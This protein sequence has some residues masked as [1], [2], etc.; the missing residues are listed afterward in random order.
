MFFSSVAFRHTTVSLFETS[1]SSSSSSSLTLSFFF[2]VAFIRW[3]PA[4]FFVGESGQVSV[5]SYINNLHPRKHAAL[6]GALGGLFERFVPLFENV[7]TEMRCGE[8]PLRLGRPEFEPSTEELIPPKVPE[9]SQVPKEKGAEDKDSGTARDVHDTFLSSLA[10]RRV[11]LK[12]RA[13]QVIVKI[14]SIELT[15]ESPQYDGGVWHIEGMRNEQICATGLFYYSC[16]NVRLAEEQE[17][18]GPEPCPDYPDC[19][20]GSGHHFRK[21]AHPPEFIEERRMF[22]DFDIDADNTNSERDEAMRPSD[23]VWAPRRDTYDDLD[24]GEDDGEPATRLAFRSAVQDP[25]YRQG[26]DAG[27]LKTCMFLFLCFLFCCFVCVC[28]CLFV[29]MLSLP[30]SHTLIFFFFFFRI[31]RSRLYFLS[32]FRLGLA[33]PWPRTHVQ[34]DS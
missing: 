31:I 9:V 15:P 10:E 11:S 13:L 4:E 32:C 7:L 34:T 16:E 26:D 25:E 24:D 29:C 6:Y 20:S 12:S 28:V 17:E 33:W 18:G 22:V 2:W 19:E 21:F 3:L 5:N 23:A 14:A 27:C 30:L 1:Q 8:K